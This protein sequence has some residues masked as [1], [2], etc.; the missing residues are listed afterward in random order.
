LDEIPAIILLYIGAKKIGNICEIR[1]RI[2]SCC[3][4]S[5]SMLID[6]RGNSTG[7]Y[8]TKNPEPC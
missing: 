4:V 1:K 6:I 8:V 2:G 7:D 5:R 3:F